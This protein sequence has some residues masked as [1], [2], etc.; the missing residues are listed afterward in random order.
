[1]AC[2]EARRLALA[3]ALL[4]LA[5]GAV[6]QPRWTVAQ[7]RQA[8]L[9]ADADGDRVLTRGEAQWLAILPRS[10]EELDANK[11]GVLSA[12]EYENGVAAS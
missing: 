10:F 7:V 1:M 9:Q 2:A 8:F 12:Q 5:L 11:D 3:G 6:A 4:G